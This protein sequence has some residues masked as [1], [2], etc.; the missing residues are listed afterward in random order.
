[1]EAHGHS[2]MLSGLGWA[3]QATAI[4]TDLSVQSDPWPGPM[5]GPG[6]SVAAV[7][8]CVAALL[9]GPGPDFGSGPPPGPGPYDIPEH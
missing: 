9:S 4:L 1:M 5:S 7:P 8:P 2:G 6:S 3:V